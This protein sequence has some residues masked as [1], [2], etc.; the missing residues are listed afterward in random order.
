[1]LERMPPE[2]LSIVL[3]QAGLAKADLIGLALCSQS[4][5]MSVAHHAH[6]NA[7]SASGS[8]VDTPILCTGTYLTDL[9]VSLYEQFP[10]IKQQEKTFNGYGPCPPRRWNW[11]AISSY[12]NIAEDDVR[13]EWANAFAFHEVHSSIPAKLF[14]KLLRSFFQHALPGASLTNGSNWTLRNLSAKQYV[15]LKVVNAEGVGSMIHVKGDPA[16]SLD[17]ALLLRICWTSMNDWRGEDANVK[18]LRRGSWAGHR[19][20][21]VR[22]IDARLGEDWCDVTRDLVKEGKKW[23][24]GE[25][26]RRF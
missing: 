26:I 12:K 16:L 20:D 17:K 18:Q 11:A 10:E 19:F 14:I 24:A 1:M 4:L 7:S 3:L 23:K 5:W 15:S 8:W 6:S 2:L 22:A 13:L 9:P 25:Q 21:V